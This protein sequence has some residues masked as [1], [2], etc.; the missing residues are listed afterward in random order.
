MMFGLGD[1]TLDM[2][3]RAS[4][5]LMGAAYVPAI[6]IVMRRPNEGDPPAW[7]Q[8]LRGRGWDRA[9]PRAASA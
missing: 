9:A 4:W 7:F 3:P 8:L 2:Y 6:L 1:G 5:V